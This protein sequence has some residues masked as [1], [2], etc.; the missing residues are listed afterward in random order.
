MDRQQA[1]ALASIELKKNETKKI[2][3][4]E[5]AEK[6][7]VINGQVQAQVSIALQKEKIANETQAMKREEE[8]AK[9]Q[10][11]TQEEE[12]KNDLKRA[13]ETH[14]GEHN[15]A[16][17]ASANTTAV[18]L[19]ARIAKYKAIEAEW[20]GKA[21][22][23]GSKAVA[24][25]RD[26]EDQKIMLQKANEEIK[27][28]INAESG[29]KTAIRGQEEAKKQQDKQ[30]TEATRNLEWMMRNE[31]QQL[32][33]AQQVAAA[34]MRQEQ[35]LETAEKMNTTSAEMSQKQEDKGS[36][37]VRAKEA[38]QNVKTAS[39][40][41]SVNAAKAIHEEI[42]K[43]QQEEQATKETAQQLQSSQTAQSQQSAE[44]YAQL[45]AESQAKMG[46]GNVNL[47]NA[48]AS[49]IALA[50]LTHRLL[51]Q[52]SSTFVP[53]SASISTAVGP[54]NVSQ[55]MGVGQSNNTML[56]GAQPANQTQQMSVGA[57]MRN[58]TA[59]MHLPFA[60]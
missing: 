15:A 57:G 7:K 11:K 55:M 39:S 43:K 34:K 54:S 50:E 56:T 6:A 42:I 32:A 9:V 36:L 2:Q 44:Q 17:E 25:K 18:D 59:Q 22:V 27:D 51:R 52:P 31:S 48:S 21:A 49:Q 14:K 16:L 19:D 60:Y 23:A 10:L 26:E 5:I 41:S 8:D 37:E 28:Q 38:E 3:E 24:A 33:T 35:E 40:E 4:A 45:L 46:N 58:I 30:V 47:T 29:L 13:E 53:Q 1:E 20:H 12:A